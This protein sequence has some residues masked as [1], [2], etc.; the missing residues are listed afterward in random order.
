M[1]KESVI[2]NRLHAF[3]CLIVHKV[4]CKKSRCLEI[5]VLITF[6]VLHCIVAY[7]HEPWYDE[8]EAWNIAVNG[9]I[10]E[11]LFEVPHYEGHPSLWH[12]VLLILS[13]LGLEYKIA[14]TFSTMFF[15]GLSVY[16]LLFKSPFPKIIRLMLPFTYFIFYQYGVIARPYSIMILAFFIMADVYD[17]RLT[18][19]YL[20]IMS[21]AF[22]CATSA[23]GVVISGGLAIVWIIELIK[24]N[25]VLT[26]LK[27][28]YAVCLLALLLYAVF[29]IYRIIP[30]NSGTMTIN[31]LDQVN[32]L[33]KRL[34]YTFFCMLPDVCVTN[35]YS[36]Y[37]YLHNVPFDYVSL[38]GTAL[39]GVFFLIGMV[40]LGRKNKTFLLFFIPYSMFA[41]FSG[42]VYFCIHHIGIL[43][44]LFM[45][46]IWVN[47]KQ[48]KQMETNN[49]E[50]LSKSML[51]KVYIV[52]C[53]V[54][55]VISIIWTIISCFVEVRYE[56]APSETIATYL[57]ENELTNCKILIA[58]E[59]SENDF[60]H[61]A[62]L[63]ELLPY[64]DNET[65]LNWQTEKPL[66]PLYLLGEDIEF[67]EA[68]R[69]IIHDGPIPDILINYPDID[70]LFGTRISMT[71]Y[72]IVLTI[73]SGHIWK[74]FQ[75]YKN[76]F[77]L[78]RK[79]IE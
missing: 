23:Y 35:T 47:S 22:L 41:L 4:E 73:K 16:Y 17:K 70:Y 53:A 5:V 68:L 14:L 1:K 78:K 69:V 31:N 54:A 77:V 72:D 52:I 32:P 34:L 37:D 56:Y 46:W 57:E 74:G 24:K 15:S 62:M 18:K 9:S 58:W 12:L 13:R 7:F 51:C 3:L 40:I 2:I 50:I 11:I 67:M 71:D 48:I 61:T 64:L 36:I 42:M 66:F 43:F 49:L 28:K 63:P 33:P 21:L 65:I 45:F 76:T 59:N 6:L 8:A 79:N 44:C 55:L 25:G 60:K 75:T 19:P 20:Y 39:I 27:S 10:K 26:S 29:I 30:Y 38:I